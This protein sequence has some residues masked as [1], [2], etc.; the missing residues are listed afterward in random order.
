M[1]KSE[2]IIL[3]IV[4]LSFVIGFFFYP[5]MPEK[6]ASH[7][8][9]QGQ[10]DDYMSKAWGLFI[11]PLIILGNALLFIAIPRIGPLRAN[12]EKFRKYYDGLAILS[13]IFLLAVYLYV[14]L[15]NMGTE[16][17]PNVFLPIGTGFLFIYI[18]IL[19]KNAKRNWFVGIRTPWT[20]SNER[21]W[22]KTHEIGGR[23]LKIAGAI[24]LSGVF[25][26]RYALFFIL[27]PVISVAV[28]T[29]IYSYFQYQKETK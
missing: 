4:L 5:R 3:V 18:G 17:S 13:L 6:M 27:V 10:A 7:W 2:I 23:L 26:R 29:I 25:F 1:R 15:W 21:V 11:F 22:E 16:I 24:A 9:F 28:Y 8:N 12:I 20:L 14:I 19:C